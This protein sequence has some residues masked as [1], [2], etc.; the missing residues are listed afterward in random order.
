M[1]FRRVLFRSRAVACGAGQVT[2]LFNGMDPLHHRRPG[3]VGAALAIDELTC[4]LIADNI[5][6]H[7]AV[8]KLAVRAKTPQR[9]MLITD[10]MSGAGMP[11]GRYLLGGQDVQV[12]DGAARLADNPS[13]LAGSTLGLDAAL[14]NIMA[15]TGLSLAEALPMATTVPAQSLGLADRKGHLA[16]GLDADLAVLD[17]TLQVERTIVAGREVYRRA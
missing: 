8:L 17:E 16:V 4:Q 2:H 10:A 6:V 14:R 13:A 9:I 3:L 1:E 5:H 12:V 15:A 11:D 7:P